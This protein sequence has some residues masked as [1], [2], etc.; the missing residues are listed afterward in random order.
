MGTSASSKGSPSGTP[1]VPP[2]VPDIQKTIKK[3]PEPASINPEITTQSSKAPARRFQ[4][5][6]RQL[7]N[8]ATTGNKVNLKKG[9]AQYVTS[10]HGNKRNTLSR[11]GGTIHTGAV[12]YD[13]L[14]LLPQAVSGPKKE[15]R[16]KLEQANGNHHEIAITIIDE[17]RPIDGSQDAEAMRT[18]MDTAFVELFK[19]NENFD[20]LN[21]Q[22]NDV[23]FLLE[24]FLSEEIYRRIELDVGSVIREK[25]SNALTASER[26]RE[27]KEFVYEIVRSEY[28]KQSKGRIFSSKEIGHFIKKLMKSCIDIF[29]EY[30]V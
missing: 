8:F 25:A 20:I 22:A 21:M 12:L 15:L 5:T 23:N 27:I 14:L 2:W 6:R 28:P 1:L 24:C 11:F 4:S 13:T 30:T 16:E 19:Q 3:P 18:S 10:G 29:A 26:I 9:I 17:L 7:G